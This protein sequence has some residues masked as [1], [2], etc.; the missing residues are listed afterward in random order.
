MTRK[1]ILHLNIYGRKAELLTRFLISV[2]K[3]HE[4]HLPFI[5]TDVSPFGRLTEK[6][7]LLICAKDYE[8]RSQGRIYST[9]ELVYSENQSMLS[10]IN[11]TCFKR[12][13]F[14]EVCVGIFESEFTDWLTKPMK[15][16]PK[17][18]ERT[19]IK[20]FY[21]QLARFA[22]Q[23]PSL[24]QK[25]GVTA[26]KR[27]GLC[28]QTEFEYCDCSNDESTCLKIPFL[29]NYLLNEE[30]AFTLKQVELYGEAIQKIY[31]SMDDRGNFGWT[32]A[33]VK[34][35]NSV[36]KEPITDPFV[37]NSNLLRETEQDKILKEF[38]ERCDEQ[39]LNLKES[40]CRIKND[41]TERYEKVF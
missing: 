39:L 9:T 40:I 37:I 1:D 5:R 28:K 33:G 2:V 30:E 16:G 23:L 15:C 10:F 25:N 38:C 20:M 34:K 3:Y 13:A 21:S 19:F 8:K 24:L 12:N 36:F 18:E 4:D 26:R 22:V 14:D 31:D 35:Y 7:R 6:Q 41:C 17:E 27:F 32:P 29:E 11:Y